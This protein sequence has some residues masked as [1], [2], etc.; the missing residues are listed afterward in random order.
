MIVL[1]VKNQIATHQKMTVKMV[2]ALM[3]TLSN[4]PSPHHDH[5]PQINEM[6]S[7]PINRTRSDISN[8]RWS[9]V[10]EE[11]EHLEKSQDYEMIFDDSACE[12]PKGYCV[13][14]SPQ[15][16]PLDNE[17]GV[18]N[19]DLNCPKAPRRLALA[20]HTNDIGIECFGSLSFRVT[21]KEADRG[22]DPEQCRLNWDSTRPGSLIPHLKLYRKESPVE[23]DNDS[24]L[25]PSNYLQ[26]IPDMLFPKKMRIDCQS[27][28]F[29]VADMR[30]KSMPVISQ[31]TKL[32]ETDYGNADAPGVT[33]LR[34]AV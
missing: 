7:T 21:R 12:I 9:D 6:Q 27:R 23:L 10:K 17:D 15:S 5:G 11:F 3:S 30:S 20:H 18:L 25:S 26:P 13:S 19:S 8:S 16:H 28:Q 32:Y 14:D 31:N 22:M 2:Q 24:W 33:N 4:S 29:E 34:P 1:R